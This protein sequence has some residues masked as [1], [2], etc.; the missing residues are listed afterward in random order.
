M[1][2]KSTSGEKEK[3][4]KRRDVFEYGS[5][6]NVSDQSEDEAHNTRN[7]NSSKRKVEQKQTANLKDVHKLSG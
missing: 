5:G 7:I 1:Q 2:I 4:R 6:D 3:K